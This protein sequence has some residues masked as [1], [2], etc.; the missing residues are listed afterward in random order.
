[1]QNERPIVVKRDC[2]ARMIPSGEKIILTLGSTVWMTQALGGSYNVMTDRGYM[3][4]IEGKDGDA[5]GIPPAAGGKPSVSSVAK[6][7]KDMEGEV[8][9]QLRSCFDPEIPVNI[10]ELGLIYH[11]SVEPLEGG[12][13]KAIVRFTLTAQGCGM[14]G[15]LKE[16]IE[17]K[18]QTLPGVRQVD[19]QLVWEPPWNQDRMSPSAKQQL[20]IE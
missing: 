11:C 10:V 19:V 5:I 4:R 15:V 13:Y 6:N 16:D 18:L 14:G 8:W 3:V 12:G 17:A 1:M 7:P 2:E 20:G 9:D